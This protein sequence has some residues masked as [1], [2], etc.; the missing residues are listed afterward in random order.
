MKIFFLDM[1]SIVLVANTDN[2]MQFAPRIL[3]GT[4]LSILCEVLLD[5]VFAVLDSCKVF[6]P[7]FKSFILDDY[8][9]YQ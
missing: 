7:V 2:Q 8:Y 9:I 5:R 3:V 1:Y 4:T 6:A